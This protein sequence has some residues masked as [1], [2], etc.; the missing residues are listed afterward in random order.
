MHLD[1]FV[2]RGQ[3]ASDSEKHKRR[4]PPGNQTPQRHAPGQKDRHRKMTDKHFYIFSKGK[5]REYGGKPEMQKRKVGR[6]QIRGF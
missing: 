5:E 2:G 6:H 3:K 4:E 1:M